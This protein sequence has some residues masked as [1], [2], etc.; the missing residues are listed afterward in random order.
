MKK[1]TSK[2][3]FAFLI[4]GILI[5]LTSYFNGEMARAI[6]TIAINNSTDVAANTCTAADTGTTYYVKSD[7]VTVRKRAESTGE[8]VGTLAKCTEVKVYCQTD[9][10]GKIAISSDK[11]VSMDFLQTS[12]SCTNKPTTEH[13][14]IS[15][16]VGTLS[17]NPSTIYHT[18]NFTASFNI[19][20]IQNIGTDETDKIGVSISNS[21]NTN[22]SSNFNITKNYNFSN[23]S[24]SITITN[25]NVITPGTYTVSIT[26][27]TG[28]TT[29]TF[30]VN[31]KEFYFDL[32][33]ANNN[34]PS[35]DQENEWEISLANLIPSTLTMNDFNVQIVNASGVDNSSN[36]TITKSGSK[37][38]IKNKK[39]VIVNW[40]DTVSDYTREGTYAVKVTLAN[41]SDYASDRVPN[42]TR[43]QNITIAKLNQI[44]Q[45]DGNLRKQNRYQI[46]YT[47]SN[48]DIDIVGTKN[49]S[50]SIYYIVNENETDGTFVQKDYLKQE[51]Q[52][53][54]PNLDVDDI[55][56]ES[57]NSN[58]VNI[59]SGD[60]SIVNY[61]GSTK[62][63]SYYVEGQ[64][65]KTESL[66]DF[67]KAHPTAYN[68]LN[69]V[70]T[71]KT[72]K[73]ILAT[74]GDILYHNSGKNTKVTKSVE[75]EENLQPLAITGGDFTMTVYYDNFLK[76]EM[77]SI[78]VDLKKV[79]DRNSNRYKDIF[80]NATETSKGTVYDSNFSVEIDKDSGKNSKQIYLKIKFDGSSDIYIGD[81]VAVLKVGNTT[82]DIS[83]NLQDSKLDY[84]V[85][86]EYDSHSMESDALPIN[87]LPYSNRNYEYYVG[88][89]MLKAKVDITEI[90]KDSIDYRIFD[91]RVDIDETSGKEYYFDEIEYIVKMTRIYNGRVYY[92]LSLDD[93]TTYQNNLSLSIA[94]FAKNYEEAYKYIEYNCID[95]KEGKTQ[96]YTLDD[97][98]YIVSD[99]YPMHVAKTYKE[100]NGSGTSEEETEY[101]LDMYVEYTT[102]SSTTI[103]KVLMDDDFKHA[104]SEMYYL[105]ATRFAYDSQNKYILGAIRGR[106][107]NKTDTSGNPIVGH[108]VTNQFYVYINKESTNPKN[109]VVI[110][111][112]TEVKPGKYYIYLTH[113]GSQGVGYKLEDDSIDAA[114]DKDIHPELWMRNIHMAEFTYGNPLYDLT[115]DDPIITNAATDTNNAYINVESYI[116]INFTLDYIYDTTKYN[117]RIE[118]NNDGTWEDA[119]NYFN[120]TSDIKPTSETRAKSASDTTPFLDVLNTSN[121]HLTTKIGT[122]K[123]GTYRV[124]MSYENNGFKTEDKVRT[125]EVSGNHYGININ[126]DYDNN[127]FFYH[128]FADTIKIPVEGY[129]VSNPNDFQLRIAYTPDKNTKIYYNWNRDNRTFTDNSNKVYFTY[130]TDLVNIGE[131]NLIYT[132]NLQNYTEENQVPIDLLLG[133]YTLEVVYQENGGD[134]SEASTTFEVKADT[135]NL[136]LKNEYPYANETDIGIKIDIETEFIPYNNLDENITYNVFY[137][138][139][140]LRDYVNVSSEKAEK[141]MFTITDTWEER[142][143]SI[144]S[145]KYNGNVF[146]HID[147]NRINLN[148]SYYLAA[149]YKEDL[150]AE[151]AISNLKELFSWS[152]K[153]K[154]IYGSFE[155]D[156][157]QIEANGFYNNVA[158][159]FI[160]VELDTIHTNEA[161][162]LITKDC[163]GDVCVPTLA[164]N[165]NDRFD[166]ILQDATHIKLKYKDN[167]ATDMR[168]KPGQYQFVVY[169]NENDYKIS[170][171]VVK[172]EFVDISIGDVSIRTKIG[173]DNYVANKMFTNKDS[174]I[175]VSARVF[176]ID[177]KKVNIKL[178][179]LD[180][181]VNFAKYFI[182]DN[183]N[184]Y[185]SHILEIEYKANSA[186]PSG[187]YL[188][189]IYYIDADGNIVEDHVSLTVNSI[190]YNYELT[191]VSYNPNP[192]VPNYENGGNIIVD[193]ETDN[194]LNKTSAENESIRNQMINN[195]S[196]TNQ[197]GEDVTNLFTK[198][199]ISTSL[200]SNF[201]L[202]LKYE[203]NTLEIGEYEI[204]MS[205]TLQGYTINKTIK[206]YVGDY[207][208]SITITGVD[209]KSNTPDGKIHNNHEGAYV[210]NYQTNYPIFTSDLNVLV[211]SSTNQDVTNKFTI[212]KNENNVEVKY[213]P[214]KT[215]IAKDTYTISLIYT[216]PQTKNVDT[217]KTKVYMYGNYKEVVIKDIVPNVSSIIAENDNQYYTF[218]LVTSNLTSEEIANLKIRVYDSYENI[219]YS[220]IPEDKAPNWFATTKVSNDEYQINILP[221]KARVGSYNVVVCISDGYDDYF[222]SNRLKLTVDDTLYKVDLWGNDINPLE[223][224]NNTDDIYNYIG[225][226]GTYNYTTTHP[227][228]NSKYSIKLFKNGVLVKEVEVTSDNVLNYRQSNFQISDLE[229]FGEIEFALCINGLPYASA[230]TNVLEYIKVT[231]VDIVFDHQ[232]VN[233]SVNINYGES[234]MFELVIKPANATNKNLIFTSLNSEVATFDGNKV[235]IVGSGSTL[236][237]LANKEYSKQF[238]INVNDQ[239][240]SN[241]YEVDYANKTIFVGSLKSTSLTKTT[242]INNLQNVASNY[243]IFDKDNNEITSPVGY[244]GTKSKLVSGDVTYT[245]IVI[246]DLNGSGTIDLGDVTTLRRIYRGNKIPDEIE[247]KAAKIKKQQNVDVGDVTTL[248][249]FYRGRINEI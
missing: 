38:K 215:E 29:R 133:K 45:E 209:I 68:I 231:N 113:N 172:S 125:F 230:T 152:I 105:I 86:S 78:S 247:L 232:D 98:G 202:N 169:Y 111:P 93:G 61:D 13:P 147:Y 43:T 59:I 3:L 48:Y 130:T 83:F 90:E 159:T 241:L 131:D 212:I 156:G 79:L 139:P 91:H 192:A 178:T 119:R 101:D 33:I 124:I 121:L 191:G 118:Y 176:G 203:S 198:S 69:N 4:S 157:K 190:Y 73:Y 235:T 179:N 62:N 186:I 144:E 70:I 145:Q 127:F 102:D 19:T 106:H 52:E 194:L 77:Q 109:D 207:E 155:L 174:S 85:Y 236:V 233:D 81:Y 66:S 95:N 189:M 180:Q 136:V 27:G 214:G 177:Y 211:T 226:N 18:N 187:D 218:N 108:E 9:N 223:K 46:V 138:D 142:K 208:R 122:T 128:N 64:S 164:N 153:E 184:F 6:K 170:D 163:G 58:K 57:K 36:F 244:V 206:F 224:I 141:R 160:D 100:K 196:I 103:N 32:S 166:L 22:V 219:V 75:I 53:T 71:K 87:V 222:E 134:T 14:P 55:T 63:V 181:S 114:I 31:K 188:L 10:W 237:T 21:S 120:I 60:V 154:N 20:S 12:T 195:V 126:N 11:Y 158:D 150:M 5:I 240:I 92:S 25:K 146:L 182:F 2:F 74:N 242:F 168:L 143:S 49:I 173:T 228:D 123:E 137:Y 44:L 245:I 82:T 8:S 94:D 40:E 28:A 56:T 229:V 205:Y 72:K 39:R 35:E 200:E 221:Y 97:N 216:D 161:N 88:V 227:D 185:D 15:F 76:N 17:T 24:M 165:Y 7:S 65:K 135:Y 47:R 16:V 116:D 132:I 162:Y 167:L 148:G 54:Y 117:Y 246:G 112:K 220:N 213:I 42:Y 171:F 129:F 67:R 84:Y 96:Y 99:N 23:K 30:T 140:S 51:L 80:K 248:F 1:Y 183:D 201:K 34:I 225:V 151:F 239:I 26:G 197:A 204:A 115:I 104:N 210:V 193:V 234:K 37:V 50:G 243:K 89:Y 41:S 175:S 149:Y 110:Y 249:R 107:Q 217:K 199:S 238:T